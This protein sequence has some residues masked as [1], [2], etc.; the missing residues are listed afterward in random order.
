MLW[1][2]S[3][4]KQGEESKNLEVS[5]ARAESVLKALKERMD[6]VNVMHTV[7]MRGKNL[8]D[9]ANSEKNRMVEVW[10]VQP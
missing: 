2:D 3:P 8:F 6:V 1:L 4:I 7:G 10:A 9:Q 5:R